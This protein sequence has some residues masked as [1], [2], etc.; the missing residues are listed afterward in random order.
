MTSR[1]KDQHSN[2]GHGGEV[3]YEKMEFKGVVLSFED[4]KVVI[5]SKQYKY[6]VGFYK[7]LCEEEK[8]KS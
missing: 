4:E 1:D 3:S 6:I 5:T 2:V 8:E 7:I